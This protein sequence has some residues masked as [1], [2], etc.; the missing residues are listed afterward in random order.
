MPLGTKTPRGILQLIRTRDRQYDGL[1]RPGNPVDRC[2][3][4]RFPQRRVFLFGIAT[5]D[6]I[7]P[8]PTN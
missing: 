5:L 1:P 3:T 7:E 6:L 4:L 8:Q 2:E